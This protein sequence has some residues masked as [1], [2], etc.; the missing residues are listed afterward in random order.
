MVYGKE[1]LETPILESGRT[2][3]QMVMEFI[4]G[5]MATVMKV[6]GFSA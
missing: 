4:N 3:R 1:S 6:N 2:Q 5:K